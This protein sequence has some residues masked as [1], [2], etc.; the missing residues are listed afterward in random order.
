M[1]MYT[2]TVAGDIDDLIFAEDY[3]VHSTKR[4]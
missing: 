1:P 2:R 3:K 4:S